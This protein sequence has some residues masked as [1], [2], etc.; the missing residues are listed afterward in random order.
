MTIGAGG[1][2]FL[3]GSTAMP[4]GP[5]L[6]KSK[7][8][9]RVVP[10]ETFKPDTKTDPGGVHTSNNRRSTGYRAR[11]PTDTGVFIT[12]ENNPGERSVQTCTWDGNDIPIQIQA[13]SIAGSRPGCCFC[14]APGTYSGDL[15]VDFGGTTLGSGITTLAFF[16]LDS[17]TALQNVE[18]DSSAL[19]IAL[20][21]MNKP[22]YG[23]IIF[24]GYANDG[25][26]FSVRWKNAFGELAKA[27]FGDVNNARHSCAFAS[28]DY[29]DAA[30]PYI[31]T[32]TATGRNGSQCIIG[33][34]L[35]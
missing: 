15:V 35:R 16:S 34:V 10:F 24:L 9:V 14:L 6:P 18:D 33:S 31:P 4:W 19:G 20:P 22:P 27:N 7:D 8:I 12:W 17:T 23:G 2:L 1:H 3:G 32:I 13:S 11:G 5:Y 25:H 29:L 28:F 21:A 30:I 26:T